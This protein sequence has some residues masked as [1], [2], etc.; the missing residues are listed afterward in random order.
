MMHTCTGLMFANRVI[1]PQLDKEQA[2]E[3]FFGDGKRRLPHF[4]HADLRQN[5]FE[6]VGNLDG[7]RKTRLIWSMSHLQFFFLRIFF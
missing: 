5:P 6:N 3:K 2:A 4:R 1:L 7:I